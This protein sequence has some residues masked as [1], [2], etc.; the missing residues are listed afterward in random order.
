MNG[1][2]LLVKVQVCAERD[3]HRLWKP[4]QVPTARI[5]GNAYMSAPLAASHDYFTTH[6]K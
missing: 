4:L 5:P 6:C 1:L 2:N 3:R